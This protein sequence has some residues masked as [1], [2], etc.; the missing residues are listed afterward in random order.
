MVVK[1]IQIYGVQTSRKCIL[2]SKK[3]K[4][5]LFTTSRQNSLV[6]PYH[7]L[8]DRQATHPHSQDGGL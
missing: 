6:G 4:V 1:N 5:G 2:K 7:C 8:L 3:L